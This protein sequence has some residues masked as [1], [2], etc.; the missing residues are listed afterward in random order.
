MCVLCMLAHN[1]NNYGLVMVIT[2]GSTVS[3]LLYAQNRPP[4]Y[5][6]IQTLF[7]KGAPY[8]KGYTDTTLHMQA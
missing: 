4:L 1:Q 8:K 6:C 5:M 3:S 2:H 7:P